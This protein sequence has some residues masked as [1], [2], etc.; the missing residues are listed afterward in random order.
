MDGVALRVVVLG[1][2]PRLLETVIE[3]L[4]ALDASRPAEVDR[5]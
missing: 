4:P 3:R 5:L 2:Q 1:E